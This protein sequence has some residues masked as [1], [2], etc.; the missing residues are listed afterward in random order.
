M[1]PLSHLEF[2]LFLLVITHTASFLMDWG[3][4]RKKQVLTSPLQAPLYPLIPSP[5]KD[6][7]T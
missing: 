6:N 3:R 2:L 5:E 1:R 7:L 4:G